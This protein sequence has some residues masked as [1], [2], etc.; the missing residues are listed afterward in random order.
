VQCIPLVYQKR[1][2]QNVK[3]IMSLVI[4]MLKKSGHILK[5]KSTKYLREESVEAKK[6]GIIG[7]WRKLHNEKLRNYSSV[8]QLNLE[9]IRKQRP[10]GDRQTFFFFRKLDWMRLLRIS[11]RKCDDHIKIILK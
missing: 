10:T 9:W 6:R 5:K 2:V 4:Y 7:V 8:Q 1:E 11:R 3:T